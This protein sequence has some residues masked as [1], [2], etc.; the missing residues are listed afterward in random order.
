MHILGAILKN[1]DLL[2]LGDFYSYLH[3]RT[4]GLDLTL[5]K[6][7]INSLRTP[8]SLHVCNVRFKNLQ[9]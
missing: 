2:Y 3:L 7:R 5:P 1:S 9:N 4:T 6:D 8:S